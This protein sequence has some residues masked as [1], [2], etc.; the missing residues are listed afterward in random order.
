MRVL[1]IV[2]YL[3]P[4]MGYQEFLLPRWNFKQGHE[5]YILTSNKYYP[6]PN[7][8]ETW[9]KFLGPR[10]T[11]KGKFKIEG[12]NV[13]KNEIFFEL[14]SRPWIK[15]L[16]NQIIKIE[17]DVI[18][19]HGTSSFSAVR[20]AW[21][22]K[23]KKIPLLLDNHMVFSIVRK[24]LIGKMYYLI[25]RNFISKFIS[26]ISYKVFGVTSETCDYLIK[27]EGYSKDKVELLQLGIDSEVFYPMK[28][29]K[30]TKSYFTVV[31]T[32]KLNNDKKPQWLANAVL[33]LLKKGH[34]IN[35]K[36]IGEG[37]QDIKNEIINKFKK[38][39][40]L[41]HLEFINF[42]SQNELCQVYNDFDLYVFPDGTSLSAVEVAAC[43]KPVIMANYEASIDREKMGIGVTYDVGNISDL[44]TK[45]EKFIISK[46]YYKEICIKSYK[47][48]LGH[49]TYDLI[50]KKFLSFC[51]E[52]VKLNEN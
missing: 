17:P 49:Y 41:N 4:N 8:D 6:V 44:A 26:K 42:K 1:H 52:A 20:A 40:F 43:M 39:N 24:S 46:D 28:I 51:S 3:M 48:V 35:L 37:S 9:K 31:Q 33:K 30:K 5:V 23:K 34:Q 15:K 27:K 19:V 16:E 21:I 18:M 11:K 50:S 38:N 32:G 10:T 45:I 2:D 25:L 12:I 14:A 36:Y 29:E 13:V 7:Y 22:C 47:T